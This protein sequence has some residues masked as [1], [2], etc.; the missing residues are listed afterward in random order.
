MEGSE[1]TPKSVVASGRN[2]RRPPRRLT[3][4]S[5]NSEESAVLARARAA[6]DRKGASVLPVPVPGVQGQRS[7]QGSL[8]YTELREKPIVALILIKTPSCANMAEGMMQL[9]RQ[10]SREMLVAPTPAGSPFDSAFVED[11][12]IDGTVMKPGQQYTKQ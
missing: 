2:H 11:V 3:R 12:T 6:A 5:R 1:G 7:A 4:L 10:S 9:E 8:R